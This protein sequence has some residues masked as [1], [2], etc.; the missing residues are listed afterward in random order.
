MICMSFVLKYRVRLRGDVGFSKSSS[1]TVG[2]VFWFEYP[3][4]TEDLCGGSTLVTWVVMFF[5]LALY[6]EE[7]AY[8]CDICR[9][10]VDD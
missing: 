4:T 8:H 9:A 5:A 7:A 2:I 6:D 1:K 10:M 3:W